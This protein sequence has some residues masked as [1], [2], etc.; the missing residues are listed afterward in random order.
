M[1]IESTGAISLGTSA[2]TGRSISG[3]FGG[4]APHS[5]SEYKSGGGLVPSGITGIPTTNSN[6][7]MSLFQGT[8]NL[9]YGNFVVTQAFQT[10]IYTFAGYQQTF[11][12]DPVVVYGSV[13]P[14]NLNGNEIISLFFTKGVIIKTSFSNVTL[15]IKGNHPK[16]YLSGI[17]GPFGSGGATATLST[18]ILITQTDG[19]GA[20]TSFGND[21]L[22]ASA[23][24]P[25]NIQNYDITRYQWIVP[26]NIGPQRSNGILNP[27]AGDGP[28]D[29][30]G[31]ITVA[32]NS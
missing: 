20:L 19:A 12:T 21:Y 4:T 32:I 22:M 2:G 26:D 5:L 3:E 27:Q 23:N 18:S 16:N 30:S 31:D 28:W 6:I 25:N 29:G 9:N 15:D 13:S 1:P 10:S 17:T 11:M 14:N 24:G 8:S 7:K